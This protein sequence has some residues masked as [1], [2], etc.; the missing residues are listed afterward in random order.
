MCGSWHFILVHCRFQTAVLWLFFH[1]WTLLILQ[2]SWFQSLID[3]IFDNLTVLTFIR[4]NPYSIGNFQYS[5]NFCCTQKKSK[6]NL[7]AYNRQ[8]YFCLFLTH[9]ENH[10]NHFLCIHTFWPS[11]CAR[12]KKNKYCMPT[13]LNIISFASY[14]SRPPNVND[15]GRHI[16]IHTSLEVNFCLLLCVIL[17]SNYFVS[18]LFAVTIFSCLL[19]YW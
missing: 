18:L 15:I 14:F 12:Q 10:F 5:D 16:T 2:L 13:W 7:N 3:C 8:I 4:M 6:Y 9:T 19:D 17:I 11:A 1:C